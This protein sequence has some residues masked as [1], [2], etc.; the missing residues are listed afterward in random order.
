MALRSVS[1]AKPRCPETSQKNPAIK[2]SYFQIDT[3]EEASVKFSKHAYQL[4]VPSN[5]IVLVHYLGD[6]NI[7][8]DFVHGNAKHNRESLYVRTCPSVLRNL[9]KK[10]ITDSTSKVYK[11]EVT[12]GPPATHRP[13]LQFINLLKKTRLKFTA[14][15][16]CHMTM[17]RG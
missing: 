1:L 17:R 4:I 7:A 13:V 14:T 10:C 12:K 8:R 16:E 11:S 6:E 9:E 5:N 2:K 15:V 3:P